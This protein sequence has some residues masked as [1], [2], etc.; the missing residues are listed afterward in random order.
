MSAQA[1]RTHAEPGEQPARGFTARAVAHRRQD[2]GD[3]VALLRV[4]SGETGQSFRKDRALAGRRSAPPFPD[5]KP[6]DDRHALQRQ[7][8]ERSADTNYAAAQRQSRRT[9]IVASRGSRPR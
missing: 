3:G 1:C 6:Y 4:A 7:V 8:T 5:P 2:I 9:D